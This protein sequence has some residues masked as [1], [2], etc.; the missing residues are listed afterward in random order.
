MTD[1]VTADSEAP[2]VEEEKPDIPDWVD[3]QFHGEDDPIQAQAQAWA[4]SQ[5]TNE[6]D[7]E[8]DE[9]SD[10]AGD[11]DS[12]AGGNPDFQV[13]ADALQEALANDSVEDSHFEAFEAM[14]IPRQFVEQYVN[15][16][17]ALGVTLANEI[18]SQAGGEEEYGKMMQWASK[19]IAKSEQE[20]FNRVMQGQDQ[21]L[22]KKMVSSLYDAY[23]KN[24]KPRQKVSGKPQVGSEVRPYGSKE[25]MMKDMGDPRY[26]RDP[27]FYAQVRQRVA[28]SDNL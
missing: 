10:S 12:D 14:G 20:M 28:L 16:Q 25:E 17:A 8:Q 18:Y 1:R 3:E 13:A 24:G 6:T 26:S 9:S 23:Q 11:G 2:P 4:N 7:E 22:K 21:D 27:A 15:A 5:T 19:S